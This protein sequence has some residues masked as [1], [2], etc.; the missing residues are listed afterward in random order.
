MYTSSYLQKPSLSPN[1][2]PPYPNHQQAF[3]HNF[4]F[5]L[6]QFHLPRYR[7]EKFCIR[8]TFY[9]LTIPN[10]N[11][12][13]E[14]SSR[15]FRSEPICLISPRELP[16]SQQTPAWKILLGSKRENRIHRNEEKKDVRGN[17]EPTR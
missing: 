11:L 15:R 17:K 2:V 5:L 4:L 12:P 3:V 10:K 7:N 6:R 1:R 9:Q 14:R 16:K 13:P 8:L